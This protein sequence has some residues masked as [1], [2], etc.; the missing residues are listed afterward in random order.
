MPA[1]TPHYVDHMPVM[2]QSN[3]ELVP[4]E[5][6][7][8]LAKLQKDFD[9]LCEEHANNPSKQPVMIVMLADG[10]EIY[11]QTARNVGDQSVELTG[12]EFGSGDRRELNIGI[13][14]ASF[15]TGVLDTGP[16]KPDLRVIEDGDLE[17]E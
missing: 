4:G 1:Y 2:P 16:R 17:D 5:A 3:P 7:T 13:G 9:D 10:T 6:A 11:I 12:L 15:Y 8:I 14:V